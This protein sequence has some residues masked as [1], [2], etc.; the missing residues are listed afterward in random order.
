MTSKASATLIALLLIP[1]FFSMITNAAYQPSVC[2]PDV[3]TC[4]DVGVGGLKPGSSCCSI[5]ANLVSNEK[6]NDCICYLV[7]INY[8][9][10]G[11]T[12]FATV[13]T[14]QNYCDVDEA[15]ACNELTKK[16]IYY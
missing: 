12:S 4:Q 11:D 10:L 16:P 13:G 15:Y 6:G 9:G 7:D 5:V 2:S 1:L 14:L 3:T 8:F